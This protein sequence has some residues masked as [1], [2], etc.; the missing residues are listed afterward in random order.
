VLQKGVCRIHGEVDGGADLRVKA[1][2]DDGSGALTAIIGRKITESLLG[3]DVE[4]CKEMAK[5]ALDQEV[6]KDELNNLLIAT[7]I[8]ITGDATIDDFGIM[9][10]AKNAEMMKTDVQKEARTLLEE[11]EG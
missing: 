11:M 7:P 3:K 9:L 8:R 5:E 4:E 1:V 10:I 6:I 2:L